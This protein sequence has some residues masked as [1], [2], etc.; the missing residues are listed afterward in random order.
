MTTKRVI[1]DTSAILS[2]M[3]PVPNRGSIIWHWIQSG[4]I[5]VIVSDYLINELIIQLAEPRFRLTPE[6]QD[7]IIA[8]YLHHALAFNRVPE[9]GVHCR[10][11]EDIP[12]LVQIPGLGKKT[13][14]RLIL[15]L[16]DK[17]RE[18]AIVPA[19]EGPENQFTADSISAL[20]SL[21]YGF[22]EADSAVRQ[23]IRDAT[24]ESSEELIRHVLSRR[25][26][27]R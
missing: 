19:G 6:Q 23:A 2:S 20:V 14:A 24:F 27:D 21:G 13:A 7:S 25:G 4:A 11:P 5:Q 3:T 15:E 8:E 10:D 9:S 22:A 17:V 16:A 26:R 18:L 12:V 1:Y